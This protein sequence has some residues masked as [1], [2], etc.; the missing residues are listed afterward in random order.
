MIP[1]PQR[2]AGK[3]PLPSGEEKQHHH[4][5]PSISSVPSTLFVAP[6]TGKHHPRMLGFYSSADFDHHF[7]DG[8]FPLFY[9][10]HCLLWALPHMPVH[11]YDLPLT[12][13]CRDIP[14]TVQQSVSVGNEASPAL[15][16]NSHRLDSILHDFWAPPPHLHFNVYNLPLTPLCW[17][18]GCAVRSGA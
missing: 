15:V 18:I 8:C 2:G 14:R 17:D 5:F 7:G 13:L 11:V 9:L 12:P 3:L 4:S 6:T 1:R 16:G 10:V